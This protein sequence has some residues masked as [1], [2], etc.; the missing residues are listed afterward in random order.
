MRINACNIKPLSISDQVTDA[1]ILSR[2]SRLHGNAG[3]GLFLDEM[4]ERA[5]ADINLGFSEAPLDVRAQQNKADKI[6]LHKYR[7]IQRNYSALFWA[8]Q[9]VGL[10]D[11]YNLILI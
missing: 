6:M 9:L 11:H 8:F 7:W 2:S 10:S 5:D 4:L 1:C 3:N